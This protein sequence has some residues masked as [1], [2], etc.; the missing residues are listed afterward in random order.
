MDVFEN[1]KG[2]RRGKICTH[3][4]GWNVKWLNSMERTKYIYIF[5]K[6]TSF[7]LFSQNFFQKFHNR[8]GI[9]LLEI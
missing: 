1:A 8:E 2:M 9:S 7:D 3:T 4:L 5:G 6:C